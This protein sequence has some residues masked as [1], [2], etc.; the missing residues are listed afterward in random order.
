MAKIWGVRRPFDR[1]YPAPEYPGD[2]FLVRRDFSLFS[3]LKT[4]GT[5]VPR[6]HYFEE[7][8]GA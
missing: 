5:F 6:R 4:A 2:L 3:R 7:C 1:S 8:V